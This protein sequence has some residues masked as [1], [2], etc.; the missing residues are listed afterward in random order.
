VHSNP[1]VVSLDSV[2]DGKRSFDAHLAYCGVQ[3]GILQRLSTMWKG[4]FLA[5]Q[6]RASFEVR[7]AKANYTIARW[8]FVEGNFLRGTGQ[9]VE[10]DLDRAGIVVP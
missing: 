5:R 1:P 6:G 3:R 8:A 4:T 7:A 2:Y 9:N 10:V